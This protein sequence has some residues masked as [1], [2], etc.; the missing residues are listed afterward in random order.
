MG[1]GAVRSINT[2]LAKP[3]TGEPIVLLAPTALDA[4]TAAGI[5]INSVEQE[6]LAKVPQTIWTQLKAQILSV[7]ESGGIPTLTVQ[8]GDS[9]RTAKRESF[10]GDTNLFLIGPVP[11]GVDLSSD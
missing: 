10:T 9:Y 11:G 5:Q 3:E 1:G 4:V 7:Y 6:F 2:T 8:N